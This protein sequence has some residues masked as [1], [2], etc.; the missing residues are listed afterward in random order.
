MDAEKGE[1]A[2]RGEEPPGARGEE[3]PGAR[4][5]EAPGVSGE[6]PGASRW[7]SVT[8]A[9]GVGVDDDG[10]PIVN[11]MGPPCRTP[12][13]SLLVRLSGVCSSIY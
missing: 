2:P 13:S 5:E 11:Q 10:E 8:W 7:A 1:E 3:A 12:G 9:N 6:A 4:G